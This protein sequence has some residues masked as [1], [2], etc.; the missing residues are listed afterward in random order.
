MSK[1]SYCNKDFAESKITIN[2]WNGTGYV[3]VTYFFCSEDCKNEI[4]NSSNKVRNKAVLFLVLLIPVVLTFILFPALAILLKM[5]GF[6]YLAFGIPIFLLG[7]VLFKYPFA[8]PETNDKWGLKK[9]IRRLKY[10][11]FILMA[12]GVLIQVINLF[13]IYSKG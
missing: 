13:V 6:I 11:G 9:S 5:K 12:F 10:T 7:F 3:N 8:T 1:C 4:I 2:A